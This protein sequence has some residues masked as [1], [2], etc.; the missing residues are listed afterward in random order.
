MAISLRFRN[1]VAVGNFNPAIITPSFLNE[2]CKLE[3]GDPLKVTP[4]EVPV[5]TGITFRDFEI[6][7]DLDRLQVNEL[8]VDN[9]AETRVIDI[10]KAF[11]TTLPYTPLKAV[12]LNLNCIL[13]LPDTN[14]ELVLERI[15]DPHIYLKFFNVE[16]LSA[17]EKSIYRENDRVWL[18]SDY[19][20]DNVNGLTRTIHVL[21]R[22]NVLVVNYNCEAGNLM[23]ENKSKLDLLLNVYTQ[24]QEEFL[25]FVQFMEE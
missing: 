9:I 15:R 20:I 12:G 5:F 25:N 10:F 4:P 22:D 13:K 16:E 21:K 6:T 23:T 18:S 2:V 8:K 11:F 19:H 1:L 24:F 7:V 3:L 14:R 17:N